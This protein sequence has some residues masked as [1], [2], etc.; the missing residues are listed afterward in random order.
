MHLSYDPKDKLEAVRHGEVEVRPKGIG[1]PSGGS[2]HNLEGPEKWTWRQAPSPPPPPAPRNCR[3]EVMSDLYPGLGSLWV[4][5]R[6]NWV[7]K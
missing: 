5:H 4:A 7:E 1:V 3:K 2:R 6:D